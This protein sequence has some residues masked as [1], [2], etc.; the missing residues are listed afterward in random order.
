MKKY[1][2]IIIAILTLLSISYTAIEIFKPDSVRLMKM[3]I[4]QD[5]IEDDIT[6]IKENVQDI[7]SKIDE[8]NIYLRN[9]NTLVYKD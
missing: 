3:E 7:V 6:E 5:N 8:I 9:R 2:T 1:N 4:K